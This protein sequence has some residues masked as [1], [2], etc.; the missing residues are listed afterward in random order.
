MNQ[1]V[2]STGF[3]LVAMLGRRGVAWVVPAA[4]DREPHD[5]EGDEDGHTEQQKLIPA[6][7]VKQKQAHRIPVGPGKQLGR[8]RQVL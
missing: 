3:G 6:A 4:T 2:P 7:G 5:H 1:A 8:V